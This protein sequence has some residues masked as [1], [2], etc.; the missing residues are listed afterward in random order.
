MFYKKNIGLE[1]SETTTNLH[2]L[3]E[4]YTNIFLKMD[5][6]GSELEW[7][8]TLSNKQLNN[9]AQLVIEF[10]FPF[11]SNVFEKIN[12]HHVLIHFHANNCC[13]VRNHKGVIIPNVF[14]C[15]FL[16]KRFFNE[17]ILN[18]EPIPSPLDMPNLQNVLDIEIKH[19]PFVHHSEN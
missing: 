15:T 10:H 19:P 9:I 1:E 4:N 18:D 8:K 7:L 11:A 3:L 12:K 2:F 5:I 6:E 14:E 17:Y 13:G 16:H